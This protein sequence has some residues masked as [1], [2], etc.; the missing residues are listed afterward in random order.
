M[1]NANTITV[2]SFAKINLGLVIGPPDY[3]QDGFHELRT[4][5]QT[6]AMHDRI[7][8]RVEKASGASIEIRCDDP[9]VP[10][11]AS[12]T[13]WKAAELLMTATKSTGKVVIT[14]EKNLPIQG[15]LGAAS[16]NAVSTMLALEKALKKPLDPERRLEIAA[17]VGSDVPLFLIG[18]T[19][20]GIGRGEQVIPLPELPPL[21]IVIVTPLIS[22]STPKA[23]R[24]WDDLFAATDCRAELR[25]EQSS[26]TELHAADLNTSA[27]KAGELSKQYGTT[28]VVPLQLNSGVPLQFKSGKLTVAGQSATLDKF[29]HKVGTWLMGGS[30]ATSGVPARSGVRANKGGDRVEALLLDLV[31]TGIGNDFEHVVFHPFP[32]LRDIKERLLRLRAKYAS[33]SG[34]GSAVYGLFTTKAQ[35]EKAAKTLNAA[36]MPAR[37]TVTLT[38]QQYW[39]QIWKS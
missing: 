31:R 33:L 28:K 8:V 10:C 27:A 26:G 5:Y 29:S 23:F 38:R 21:N 25:P 12:N 30:T 14:I 2:R 6:V 18:G 9:R 7:T 39:R 22:I 16:G 1:S 19:V 4:V 20:L 36:G 11:D 37:A 34:S 24:D 17:Q 3:R 32:A 13:C 15:G 35:A